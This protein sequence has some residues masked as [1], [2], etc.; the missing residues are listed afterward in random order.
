MTCPFFLHCN[1]P[2]PLDDGDFVLVLTDPA[3]GLFEMACGYRWDSLLAIPTLN[4]VVQRW[5][6]HEDRAGSG[7][8]GG[9]TQAMYLKD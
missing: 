9:P 2:T 4:E 1:L 6:E 5:P 3:Y 8:A 7:L